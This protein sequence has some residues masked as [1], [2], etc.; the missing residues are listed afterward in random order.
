MK[1]FDY[2]A[3]ATFE[4]SIGVVEEKVIDAQFQTVV[5]GN[6]AFDDMNREELK[7]SYAMFRH[8]WICARLFLA[9]EAK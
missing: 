6:D 1:G 7:H 3:Y 2:D 5:D 9:G 8:R 4:K